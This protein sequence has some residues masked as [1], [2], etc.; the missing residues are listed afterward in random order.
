MMLRAAVT[1]I[2]KQLARLHARQLGH[3]RVGRFERVAIVGI[4]RQGFDAHHPTTLRS[5]RYRHLATKLI[6]LVLFPFGDA[7][8]FWGLHAVELVLVRS[9]LPLDATGTF[10][11]LRQ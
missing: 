10:E 7:F 2:Y 8:H 11:R 9:F 6:L 5:G 3:L 4:A 1:A